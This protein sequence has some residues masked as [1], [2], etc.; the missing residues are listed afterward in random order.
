MAKTLTNQG[1]FLSPTGKLIAVD[2]SGNHIGTVINNPK[3][4]GMDLE[5]IKAIYASY[6][7]SFRTEGNAREAI[8]KGLT[9]K[10][11]IRLRRYPNKYWSVQFAKMNPKVRK[12][13][14]R[15]AAAMVKGQGGYIEKDKYMPV[16]AMGFA[17]GF[18]KQVEINTIAKTG[19]IGESID[20]IDICDYDSNEL[21]MENIML[22]L[23]DIPYNDWSG[24]GEKKRI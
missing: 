12:L 19:T 15:W 24:L 6:S 21:T 14:G 4:F 11:W 18:K 7:E 22:K 20:T 5:K 8:L 23:S 16:I 10:G 17:D 9:D 1:F 3:K 13:L 2:S